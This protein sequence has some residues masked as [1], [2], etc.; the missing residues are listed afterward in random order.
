MSLLPSFDP[1]TV[2]VHS[3][4]LHLDRVQPEHLTPEALRLRFRAPPV[5]EP[6][7]SVER[8]FVDRAPA[9]AKFV[10][11]LTFPESRAESGIRF[12]RSALF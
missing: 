5:W 10:K 9:R 7:S 3:V 1:R 6:E 4:D 8:R 12:Q 2:P 11:P